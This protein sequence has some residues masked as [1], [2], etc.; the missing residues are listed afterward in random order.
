MGGERGEGEEM[1]EGRGGAGGGGFI[2]MRST[3]DHRPSYAYNADDAGAEHVEISSTRQT[4]LCLRQ[5]RSAGGEG[6]LGGI[7]VEEGER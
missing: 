6:D 4:L 7:L 5:A 3:S 1:D 2:T